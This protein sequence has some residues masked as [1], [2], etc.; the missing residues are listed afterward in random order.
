MKCFLFSLLG[1]WPFFLPLWPGIAAG[2]RVFM[3]HALEHREA[4]VGAFTSSCNSFSAAPNQTALKMLC[5]NLC[6][7]LGS[8]KSHWPM[9]ISW[10]QVG[11]E[12]GP[13]LWCQ[14]WS[15]GVGSTVSACSCVQSCVIMEHHSIKFC[16]SQGRREQWNCSASETHVCFVTAALQEQDSISNPR[17]VAAK[18][19]LRAKTSGA[20][21]CCL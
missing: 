9:S 10:S 20:L 21:S 3:Y 15:R 19:S 16:G 12:T 1:T 11:S 18:T 13:K 7:C 5:N 2:G 14:C 4:A 8:Q 6:S 17:S